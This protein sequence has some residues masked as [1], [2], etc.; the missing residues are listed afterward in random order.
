MI[1]VSF[2][3]QPSAWVFRCSPSWLPLGSRGRVH[4]AGMPPHPRIGV[5]AQVHHP[6]GLLLF[7]QIPTTSAHHCQR[8]RA[9]QALSRPPALS[10][11]PSSL[12]D[13]ADRGA[14]HGNAFCGDPERC[15]QGLSQDS[16]ADRV[17]KSHVAGLSKRIIECLGVSA[18]RDVLA[19][20][21]L[22]P[23]CGSST[24]SWPPPP[25]APRQGHPQSAALGP[26]RRTEPAG[27]RRSAPPLRRPEQRD[28]SHGTPWMGPPF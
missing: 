10:Q 27:S 5:Q 2:S 20:A 16:A 1:S 12:P 24:P 17:Q 6:A 18:G 19:P 21:V 22:Q 23:K 15:V 11:C 13:T 25:G 4:R 26:R 3:Q 7:T 14:S 9:S 28:Q 8:E